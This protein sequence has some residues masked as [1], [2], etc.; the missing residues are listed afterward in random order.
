M[1][2]SFL[3][4]KNYWSSNL[5]ESADT[6]FFETAFSF[7]SPLYSSAYF[8]WVFTS[9]D[10]LYCQSSFSLVQVFFPSLLEGQ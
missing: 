3:H 7:L 5:I 9:M 10:L 1:T 8:I 6:M 4:F 2:F